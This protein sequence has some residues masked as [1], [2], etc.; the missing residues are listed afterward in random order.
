M[1]T[2]DIALVIFTILVQMSV[3]AFLVLEVTK[4]IASRKYEKAEVERFV[5]YSLLSIIPVLVVG[6]IASFFHLGNPINAYR[7]V[8]NIGT[9]WLSREIFFSVSFTILLILYTVLEFRK[10]GT[11]ALK[12]AL[13]ILTMIFGVALVFSMANI[14]QLPTHP[15]WKCCATPIT[16]S[17][18]T[19]LLGILALGA[20]FT[21]NYFYQK[22]KAPNSDEIQSS[23]LRSTLRWFALASVVLLGLEMVVM[24]IYMGWLSTGQDEAL[25]S[26]QLMTG[27]YGWVL[28]L[29]LVLVFLGAGLV[30]FFLYQNTLFPGKERLMGNLTYFAFALVLTAEVLGRFLFYATSLGI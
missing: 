9:S 15:T 24:P 10:V 22:K 6:L 25:Q 19:L 17:I 26:A 18:T 13:S 11:L 23:L 14:Y 16:F 29:R 8:S 27:T 1:K 21:T 20:V 7:A 3:G 4:F 28:G 5:N 2:E 30:V 12:N